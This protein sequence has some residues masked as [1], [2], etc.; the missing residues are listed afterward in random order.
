MLPKFLLTRSSAKRSLLIVNLDPDIVYQVSKERKECNVLRKGK[1]KG[2]DERKKRK[3]CKIRHKEIIS[4]LDGCTM[5]IKKAKKSIYFSSKFLLSLFNK[6]KSQNLD[7]TFGS[8]FL[9]LFFNLVNIL[10][11]NLVIKTHEA[12]LKKAEKKETYIG[13]ILQNHLK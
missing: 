7:L 5:Q 2:K 10:F 8:L 12:L 1:R 11:R 9:L 6:H 13:P 4:C 3:V